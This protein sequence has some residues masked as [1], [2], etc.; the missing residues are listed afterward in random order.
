MHFEVVLDLIGTVIGIGDF[1][2]DQTRYRWVCA[3]FIA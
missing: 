1:W 2:N 3:S